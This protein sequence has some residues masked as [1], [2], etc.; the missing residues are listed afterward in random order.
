MI[1]YKAIIPLKNKK[2]QFKITEKKKSIKYYENVSWSLHNHIR[3][4][5]KRV[6]QQLVNQQGTIDKE[7]KLDKQNWPKQRKI[8]M[9]T[10]KTN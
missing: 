4:V 3:Q 1:I 7:T 10:I 9:R 8:N 6:G 2:N 5:T